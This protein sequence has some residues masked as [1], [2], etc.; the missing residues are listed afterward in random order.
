[1]CVW[2]LLLFPLASGSFADSFPKGKESRY[3]G[4]HGESSAITVDHSAC[5]DFRGLN[6]Y[7]GL[8]CLPG[9]ANYLTNWRGRPPWCCSYW[10]VATDPSSR[11][12]QRTTSKLAN[13]DGQSDGIRRD[14]HDRH[15]TWLK[16]EETKIAGLKENKGGYRGFG[17]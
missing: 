6:A 17:G 4:G 13:S 10:K 1:M 14:H 3:I 9:A 16:K 5:T 11:R 12:E 8:A 15:T 7:R 2:V